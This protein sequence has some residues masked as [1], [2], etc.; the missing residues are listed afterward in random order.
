MN[1]SDQHEP[2]NIPP[3]ANHAL[4]DAIF[5]ATPILIAHLDADFNFVRVNRAYAQADGKEPDFFPG[6]N[7]FSLFPND[8]NEAIFSQVRDTGVRYATKAKPFEYEHNPERGVT[9]WDWTLTPIVE[10]GRVAWLILV[11]QNVTERVRDLEALARSEAQLNSSQRIARLG[12]WE[13]DLINNHLKWSDEIFRIFEIDPRRFGASYEDFLNAVHPEDRAKVDTAYRASLRDHTPYEITHRLQMP[14]GRVKWV[15]E[16]CE[17]HFDSSGKPLRSIGTVQDITDIYLSQ[18][19]LRDTTRLLDL[20]VENIPNMI[21]MKHA[22]DLRFA[23]FNKAGEN[24]IGL[25]REAMLGHTDYDFFPKEQADCF[26]AKDRK[27]LAQQEGVD[28]PEEYIDTRNQGRRILHTKKIALRDEHGAPRYLLG[29][30]EDITERIAARDALRASEKKLR[31]ILDA[32]FGCVG[33]YTLDGVVVDANN[34]SLEAAGLRREDVLGLPFWDTYWWNHDAG[35]QARLKDA[36][37]R[38]ARGE[39]VRYETEVRVKNDRRITIDVTFRPLYDANSAIINIV[40]Y[41]V[42]ITERKR[43]ENE[44]RDLNERL[45]QRVAQRARELDAERDFIATVLD[46]AGALVVVLDRDG[47][48]VRF[49]RACE[50]LTGYRIQEVCGRPI[51]ELVIPED[52]RPAVR[53]VFDR[54]LT[55]TVPVHYEN[56]WL[57][58]D[59]SRRLIAWSN[60]AIHD[61]R[62]SVQ[63]VI[64][65]G[66]DITARK[67]AEA[68]LV[69]AK[70]EAERAN[71]AKSEFLS[72]MSHELRTPLNA[73]LGFAQLL[74]Q[75]ATPP[76]AAGDRE[77]VREILRA[78]EHLLNLIGEILD[79]AR[80]ES[81]KLRILIGSLSVE[82]AIREAVALAQPLADKRAIELLIDVPHDQH[83]KV[84]A[85]PVRLKQVLLN[86][87]SNAIKFNRKSGTVRIRCGEVSRTHLKILVTDTGPGFSPQQVERLFVP[88]ERFDADRRA[89]EGSGIGLALSKRLVELMGGTIGLETSLGVGSTF[90]ISLPVADL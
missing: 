75:Y 77:N 60:S 27:V 22:G 46:T 79:L 54:L 7:H 38:A 31:D 82:T 26:T 37:R 17:S 9:H 70:E 10:D 73:I 64:G 3:S 2:G 66:I 81:G 78:G 72:R 62:G 83:S 24:L 5:H 11:L 36:L 76:L 35:I 4:F 61:G 39:M 42:D 1:A 45:E 59:G 34:A 29:I 86:L 90:W 28:I 30:S 21:F 67:Q 88:F 80:I 55:E 51:W 69:A 32:I 85:D 23:L 41:G 13:M 33:L 84:R 6:K 8:E 49:N 14:D 74:D 16:R 58:R 50:L 20:I 15:T 52:Q 53:N 87:L 68:A 65:T 18:I 57:A 44:L 71:A 40:G 63:Y 25:K 12:S 43:V 89:I 48:V 19:Q 47:R 56:D